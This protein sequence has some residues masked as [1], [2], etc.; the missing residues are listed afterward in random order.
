ML[1]RTAGGLFWMFRYLERC[2]N[3]SRLVEAG[4]RI[5]LTRNTAAEQEWMSVLDTADVRKA[6]D[7]R[8][9]GYNGENVI[10]F[11]LRDR[12]HP[13]SVNSMAEAARTNA[14]AVRTALTREVFEAVNENYL[15]LR[16]ALAQPVRDRDLPAVL[17]T[18][19]QQSALVRGAL[20]GTM[21]R[22]DIYDFARLGTFLERAD[23]TARILDV[24][25]YVL[26]PSVAHVGAALDNVQWETILRALSSL[27][28][29]RWLTQDKMTAQGIGEFLILDKRLP[30][31]LAFCSAA[32]TSNLGEIAKE[33]GEETPSTQ[34]AI[35]N[36]T[37]LTSKP[38]EKIMEF[39]L[40]E[41]LDAF[42]RS[43]NTLAE[44]IERDYRFNE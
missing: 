11:L 23:N 18:I 31:S 24:K 4:F 35:E 10:N 3:T 2:E 16:D 32:I 9:S 39:G 19:R 17:N 33:Y 12:S 22:N 6:Y 14:R 15:I 7:D 29:Y 13:A 25:Y 26:L 37:R 1:G 44:Q 8:Y 40:H 20:H 28:A 5:A 30:R 27:R 36:E 42:I 43:N 34:L 21:L 41:T 38:I